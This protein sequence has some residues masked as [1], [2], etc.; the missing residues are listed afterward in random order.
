MKADVNVGVV[1][2]YALAKLI[3]V[4]VAHALNFS[5]KASLVLLP[6]VL[7]VVH[8]FKYCH[9]FSSVFCKDSRKSLYLVCVRTPKALSWRE[10]GHRVGRSFHSWYSCPQNL[11]HGHTGKKNGHLSVQI[12]YKFLIVPCGVR[13]YA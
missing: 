5:P 7:Y 9:I 11:K 10:I 2:G 1:V 8:D 4:L 6:L 3:N 13:I 12:P